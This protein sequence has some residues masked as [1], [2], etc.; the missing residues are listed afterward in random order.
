MK[1]ITF[2]TDNHTRIGSVLDD[3]VI[4]LSAAAPALPTDMKSFLAAGADAWTPRT[5]HSQIVPRP[6]R[7][8]R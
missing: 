3:R 4:D 1:L 8:R 5:K 7:W 6:F 2:T